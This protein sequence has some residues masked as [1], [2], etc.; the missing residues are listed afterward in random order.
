MSTATLEELIPLL[1]HAD[2]AYHENNDP[3]LTDAE[4]DDLVKQYQT[5][6]GDEWVP[7]GKPSEQLT[8]IPHKR[9][10]LSL[11]KFTE[12]VA[13]FKWAPIQGIYIQT[14]KIDGLSAELRYVDGRWKTAV[15][16]G[17][18]TVG[19]SITH[20][21]IPIAGVH[22]P[23]TLPAP[24]DQGEVEIRG[25]IYLPPR[26]FAQIGGKNPR[27]VA[28]GLCRRQEVGPHHQHLRFLA[29]R[30]FGADE[31]TY[32]EQ[33]GNLDTAGF[34]TPPA[35][36][37][38]SGHFAAYGVE[39]LHPN[40]WAGE[41]DYEID[42]T[43]IALD[44]LNAREELGDTTSYPRWAAAFKFATEEKE[45]T[46]L[47]TEWNANRTGPV[48]P[49]H[50]FEAVH[51]CGTIVTRATG[52]NLEQFLK[53]NAAPGDIVVAK[54]AN[55]IIPQL[56]RVQEKR[57]GQ[58]TYPSTCPA[59][60][61]R[62]TV[63]LPHLVCGNPSCHEKLVGVLVNAAKRSNLDISG[64]GEE[65]AVALVN[66]GVQNLADLFF[67]KPDSL[68]SMAFGK[69]TFGEARAKKLWKEV[70][71]A[72]EKPWNVVLHSLGCPGLGEPECDLIAARFS[73][74]DIIGVLPP[75]VLKQEL[76]TMRGIGEKTAVAFV[77]WMKVSCN[78]LMLLL[79][80]G[81][82]TKTVQPD[83]KDQPLLGYT[84][85]MTGS[86]S[87][88]SRNDYKKKLK[89]LGA[90]VSDS[91]SKKTTLLIAGDKPGADKMGAAEK[92]GVKVVD[93][94]YLLELVGT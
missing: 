66:G 69:G 3:I 82:Q 47:G 86:F 63:V 65:V 48:V 53:L 29:Y 92:Y 68:A 87:Q 83:T 50:L 52:H 57:G 51:L 81:L 25:E 62:L 6:S 77:E 70:E 44:D 31:T 37:L 72:K 58:A 5:L 38:N 19:E 55:E 30:A 91:V 73:L 21:L 42:G 64:L 15:S 8:R 7:L 88:G 75:S 28:A 54:K 17:D 22:F 85:V 33:L 10:M 9:P 16:R 41:M 12:T 34:N 18:G 40:S 36:Q 13:L 20:A 39:Q 59:C 71:K 60:Q 32:Q 84:I 67:I 2:Q 76:M 90:T 74:L 89:D 23:L 14:P 61:T 49:T 78:W 43:V 56:A 79:D 45:T 24:Y 94:Q 11:Q 1:R 80:T 26:L 27:N 35:R 93:E 4:Y 46:Y